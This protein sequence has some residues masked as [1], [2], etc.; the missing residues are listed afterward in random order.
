MQ[1][2]LV[3]AG[4]FV[5]I[6]IIGFCLRRIGFFKEGD[7]SV[8]SRIVIKITLP[9]SIIYSFSGKNFDP[10]LLSLALVGLG[11]GIIYMIIAYLLNMRASKEQQSF[12]VL[13][14]AGLNIG[15]F[16]MPFAQCFFGPIGI[17]TTSLCD[18][19]N[20]MISLGGAY[21]VASMIKDKKGFSLKRLGL[22]LIKSFPFDCYVVMTILVLLHISL[23]TPVISC[24][25][26]IAN[27]NA[28]LAMLMLGVGFQLSGNKSQIH[29]I[30]RILSVRY[31]VSIMLALVCYFLLPFTLEVR[32]ALVILVFS[33]LPT[34]V[35]G[36]TDELKGDVG[37][38]SA[39]NSISM[40]ISIV[41][42]VALLLIML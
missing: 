16:T 18:V 27:G 38:S 12:E 17:I 13:N 41:C 40:I 2:I 39:L 33:P 10:A 37:L 30:V 23:P 1:D 26:I 42:I 9:A 8:L 28:F 21:S 4:C 35:P 22:N 3:R 20:A 6:I 25:E 19:G 7:F 15:A 5:A 32:Q 14:T 34:A 24:A 36:F 29:Q 31:I 11:S